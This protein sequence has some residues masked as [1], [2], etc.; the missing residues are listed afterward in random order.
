MNNR[1]IQLMA[2][3]NQISVHGDDVDRMCKARLLVRDL[4]TA[5]AQPQGNA[6]TPKP[7]EQKGES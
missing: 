1:L 7:T 4:L 3:L 2:I 6:P 5:S